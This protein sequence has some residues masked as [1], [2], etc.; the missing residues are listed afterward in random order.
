MGK[1]LSK[2]E[3]RAKLRQSMKNREEERQQEQGGQYEDIAY[4]P[5]KKKQQTVVRF[6]GLPED[7]REDGTDVRMLR[8]AMIKDDR[9]K[10]FRAVFPKDIDYILT[11]AYQT[12]CEYEWDDDNNSPNY[13]HSDQEI[14]QR[15]R[16]NDQT[17]S[18]RRMATGWRPTT[19]FLVNVLDR[20]D[21]DWHK[22]NQHTKAIAKKMNVKDDRT[23]Y[24]PGIP[25]TVYQDI[26]DDIVTNEDNMDWEE[27]DIAIEKLDDKPWYRV[28]HGE[29]DSH[30]LN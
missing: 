23:Y 24:T 15:V 6:L 28:Y 1:R 18:A 25:S 11:K 17:G 8:M 20:S 14:F 30:R 7:A 12:V 27:Y 10:W 16:Y 22:E 29:K 9:G 26:R 4:V 3:R 21:P 19:T 13:L 5:L 2:E